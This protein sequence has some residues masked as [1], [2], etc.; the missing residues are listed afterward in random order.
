M[1]ISPRSDRGEIGPCALFVTDATDGSRRVLHSLGG[2]S[3]RILFEHGGRT[4]LVRDGPGV[5]HSFDL[6]RGIGL[7]VFSD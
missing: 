4:L 5:T 7:Q 3:A 1:G 6:A 2:P